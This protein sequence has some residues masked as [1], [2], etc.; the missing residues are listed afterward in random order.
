M[1][2]IRHIQRK[3]RALAAAMAAIL[4]AATATACS[5]V[6]AARNKQADDPPPVVLVA[7]A[8]SR[9]LERNLKLEAELQPFQE[10]EVHAKVAG[11]VKEMDV[12]LGSRVKAGQL[13]A[14]L[15]VPELEH[16]REQASA[17]VV[18]R[19]AEVVRAQED[20][21]QAQSAHEAVHL[22]A[23]RLS[24]LGDSSNNMVAQQEIDDAISKD[25]SAEA[26]ISAARA[27]L[28]AA[29]AAFADARAN[30]EKVRS[31]L[32]YT[33]IT[34][35]F[36]GVVSHRY[37]DTGTMLPAGTSSSTQ[38]LP[39]VRLTQDD[40]L[41]LVILVPETAVPFIHAGAAV[42]ISV[43]AG[44]WTG[45]GQISRSAGA[46]DPATRTMRVEVNVPNPTRALA[47][48]EDAV[49]EILLERKDSALVVPLAAVLSPEND[50]SVLAVG[51]GNH[52]DR[53][54]VTLG[55]ETPAEFEILSGIRPNDLVVVNP[56]NLKP[57]QTVQPK[58][59][60]AAAGTAQQKAGER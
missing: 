42:R 9:P 36:S 17:L 23:N 7:R 20:L 50:P 32:E 27:A 10:V 14:T 60:T 29:E 38:A 12:D 33:R 25:K 19:Q 47:P 57:G 18:R 54:R 44:K 41:R 37:A 8:V 39:L 45:E 58:L 11:Y 31:L 22:Q 2:R 4:L 40:P 3:H 28:S 43:P 34:A 49:V 56:Q 16:E 48:G 5:I 46:L 30:A 59:E 15:S 53:R 21:K 13:L 6:K 24:A 26:R 1:F 51:P 52:L 35:P 55:A